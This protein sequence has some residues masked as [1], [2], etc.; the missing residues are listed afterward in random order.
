[1]KAFATPDVRNND[2]GETEKHTING[3]CMEL[4]ALRYGLMKEGKS[5]KS[6]G[7]QLFSPS[8]KGRKLCGSD[9]KSGGGT[10][11]VTATA[12]VLASMSMAAMELYPGYKIM[13]S[14][15]ASRRI[16]GASGSDP[17][18]PYV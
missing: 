5:S 3:L 4:R 17:H 18:E 10:E 12:R 7:A 2:R 6:S 1:M 11:E 8:V 16:P 14:D 13:S 15:A 9:H